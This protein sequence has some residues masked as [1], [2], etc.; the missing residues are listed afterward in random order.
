METVLKNDFIEMVFDRKI[1]LMN[2]IWKTR[3]EMPRNAYRALMLDYLAQ[4]AKHRPKLL[5]IDAQDA[6]YLVDPHDQDWIN[7]NIYPQTAEAGVRRI[8]FVMGRDYFVQVSLEQVAS[9]SMEIPQVSSS[10]AQNFFDDLA[11]ALAWLRG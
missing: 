1:G 10:I 6:Q 3:L 11:S 8:A 7:N 5:L 4:L 2:T 9:D